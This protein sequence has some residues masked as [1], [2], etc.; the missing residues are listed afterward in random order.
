MDRC[1]AACTGWQRDV[2]IILR[3]TGLRVQQVMHLKW[4]DFDL[5]LGILKIRGELGKTHQERS[6]RIIPVSEY[7]VDQLR[8]MAPARERVGFII[9]CNRK[10]DGP[11]GRE[12]RARDMMR[13][14]K[15]AGVREDV[16]KQ[17]PHHAFRKGFRSALKRSGADDM[18]VE[19]L[20]GHSLGIAGVYTDPDA[21]PLRETV[22]LIPP[23]TKLGAVVEFETVS[24]KGANR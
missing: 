17:R 1:V 19:F 3:Y 22:E 10:A 8:Q 18:A 13:A 15:R 24:G 2:A 12:A 20:L 9:A 14:W 16:W 4:S 6:G 11:R 23:M 5:S 7:L 21:M